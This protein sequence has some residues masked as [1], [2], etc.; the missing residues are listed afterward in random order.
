MWRGENISQRKL[1]NILKKKKNYNIWQDI[2][3]VYTY[4]SIFMLVCLARMLRPGL[5]RSTYILFA[6]WYR[7]EVY[8]NFPRKKLL[9]LPLTCLYAPLWDEKNFSQ[10]KNVVFFRRCLLL[11]LVESRAMYMNALHSVWMLQ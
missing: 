1:K 10:F 2:F 9:L 8:C 3:C 11:I 4:I 7:E 5:P 6:S